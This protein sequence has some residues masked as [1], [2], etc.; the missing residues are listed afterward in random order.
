MGGG[1]GAAQMGACSALVGRVDKIASLYMTVCG[2]V[3]FRLRGLFVIGDG[4]RSV[5][6]HSKC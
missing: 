1:E 6:S 5:L 3:G 4:R 2:G